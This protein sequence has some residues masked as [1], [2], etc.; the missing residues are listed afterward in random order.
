MQICFSYKK[1]PNL[2]TITR[3]ASPQLPP[4][5]FFF[6]SLHSLQFHN[7]VQTLRHR[8]THLDSEGMSERNEFYLL[9]NERT[10]WVKSD[11]EISLVGTEILSAI[12]KSLEDCK[13]TNSQCWNILNNVD[14]AAGIAWGKV[15]RMLQANLETGEFQA[16][17]Q[18]VR[19]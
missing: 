1:I 5:G 13:E 19:E 8:L 9:K 17:N 3:H 6:R 14:K 12:D 16:N 15:A 10:I 4:L 2:L 11:S 7:K 18:Q